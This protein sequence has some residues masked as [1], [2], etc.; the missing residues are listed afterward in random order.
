[1]PNHGRIGGFYPIHNFGLRTHLKR[2]QSD[3]ET[4]IAAHRPNL[5]HAVKWM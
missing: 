5:D 4:K 3:Y 2:I 1:M